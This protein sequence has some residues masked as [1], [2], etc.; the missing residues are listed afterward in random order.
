M[1]KTAFI[2]HPDCLLH[3][4]P[5]DIHVE[6]PERL[7]EIMRVTA[8]IDGIVNVDAPPPAAPK[9]LSV[10]HSHDYISKVLSSSPCEFAQGTYISQGTSRAALAAVGCVLHGVENVM[11]GTYK[12]AFCAV[13]PPGHHAG[14]TSAGGFCLFN[15]IA[16]GALTALKRFGAQRIAIVDFDIHHGNGTQEII[17]NIPEVSYISTHIIDAHYPLTGAADDKGICDNVMNIP[18]TADLHCNDFIALYTDRIIPR[19]REFAPDIILVSAGFDGHEDDP[20]GGYSLKTSDYAR[21]AEILCSV[22]YEICGGRIV[23]VLEG[24]YYPEKTAACV[25]EFLRVM[26]E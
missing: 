7:R 13:R 19:I 4:V 18:F 3:D 12:N 21:L 22:A 6:I 25:K 15:N 17:L 11:N 23:F 9:D 16:I 20:V 24:G 1:K 10:A 2:T 14:R 26:K 8:N 5:E